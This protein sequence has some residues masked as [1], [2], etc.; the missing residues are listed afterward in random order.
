MVNADDQTSEIFVDGAF[1]GNP[2]A[3]LK[4]PVGTHVVEVRKAG[5][6]DYRRQLNVV[7]GSELTLRA[8]LEKE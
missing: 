1:V 8:R 4:L 2:P 3:R 5:F 6:K 7:D